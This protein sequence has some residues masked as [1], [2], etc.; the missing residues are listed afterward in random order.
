[1]LRGRIMSAHGIKADD[2]KPQPNA[3]WVLQSDRGITFATEVPRGST[4]AEGEWWPPTIAARRWS[5]SRRR[6]PTGSA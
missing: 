1:M 3:A 4:V 6:S 5:R 2:L